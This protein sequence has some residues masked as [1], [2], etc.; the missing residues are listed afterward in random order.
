MDVDAV[1]PQEDAVPQSAPLSEAQVLN[2]A[3][4]FVYKIDDFARLRRFTILGSEANNYYV[5]RDELELQNA[6]CVL[7]LLAEGQGDR[8]VAEVKAISLEG[9]A[10]RQTSGI[11]VLAMCAR[12]GDTATRRAALAALPA[13]CRT[14]STLFEF[15]QRCKELGAAARHARQDVAAAADPAAILSWVAQAAKDTTAAADDSGASGGSGSGGKL[16]GKRGSGTR[17]AV[18][19]G[20]GKAS[21][22]RAMRRAVSNWYLGRTPAAVAYQA[23][24]YSQRNGWSHADVLRLAHPDP[25]AHAAK[26]RK[27]QQ[28]GRQEQRQQ[29]APAVGEGAADSDGSDSDTEWV[30]LPPAG[31]AADG[32][33]GDDGGAASEQVALAAAVAAAAAA[34]AATHVSEGV[35]PAE[36]AAAAKEALCTADMKAVFAFLTHGTLPGR[37]PRARGRKAAPAAAEAAPAAAEAAAAVEGCEDPAS[38]AFTTATASTTD[39]DAAATDAPATAADHP[40]HYQKCDV[41]AFKDVVRASTGGTLV[42]MDMRSCNPAT[43]AW[44]V[45]EW[46]ATLGAHGPDGLH[47]QV[48]AADRAALV[49]SLDVELAECYSPDDKIAILRDVVEQHGSTSEFNDKLKLQLMLQPLSYRVDLRRLTE[50]ARGTA[51]RFGPVHDW[52]DAGEGGAR[53]LCVLAGAGE[54]KSTISAALCDSAAAGQ[55]VTA[56]HFV[57]YSD[58]RRLDPLRAISSLAFQLADRLPAIRPH[59]FKVD[60]SKLATTTDPGELFE[61]LL[62]APLQEALQPPAAATVAA[63]A[64]GEEAPQEQHAAGAG[65]AASSQQVVLLIDALDEADP[66]VASSLPDPGGASGDG[67]GGSGHGAAASEPGAP[68]VEVCG[69]KIFQLLTRQLKSLPRCVRFILTARPDAVSGDLRALLDRSFSGGGGVAYLT[70]RQLRGEPDG[71]DDGGG[72]G[73][74]GGGGGAAAAAADGSNAGGSGVLVYHTLVNECTAKVPDAADALQS[75]AAA[76]APAGPPALRDLHVAYGCI[77]TARMRRL[78][79]AEGRAVHELLAVLLAAQEPLPHSLLHALGLGG[80]LALLPGYPVTFFLDEHHVYTL[81]KSL[82][83]W[84]AEPA[85]SGMHAADAAAGH[86]RLAERL[87]S[88]VRGTAG[89]GGG[90]SL[91]EYAL[92]YLV[93]HLVACGDLS[94]LEA[95]LRDYGF[96]AAVFAQGHGHGVIR[97][98]LRAAQPTPGVADARRWLL[99]RQHELVGVRAAEDVLKDALD[100]PVGTL[101]YLAAQEHVLAGAAAAG[102][103]RWR[104]Q[105]TLGARTTWP[106]LRISMRG[107][108]GWISSVAWSPDGRTVASGM[109]G[110]RVALWNAAS[111]ECIVV[112]DGHTDVVSSVCWQP[113][114]RALASGSH[115]GTVRLWDAAS[116]ECMGTL[117]GC[118]DG[119]SSVAWSPDGR[120]L[121]GGSGNSIHCWDAAS[122]EATTVLQGHSAPVRGVAWRPDSGA[123]ASASNDQMLRL[124]DPKS[125]ACTAVLKGH[126]GNALTVAWSPDGG[127]LASGG[128][129]EMLVRLWDAGPAVTAGGGGAGTSSVALSQ[130][131]PQQEQVHAE[132]IASVSWSPDG[133]AIASASMDKTLR[134]WDAASGEC[135]ATL[136]GHI[137][138]VFSVA[139][140]PSGRALA[141][142]SLDRTV[143]LWDAAS[144]ECTATLEG[145]GDQ[146]YSVSWSPDGG[147]VA[148]G[149]WDASVRVWDAS[150]GACTSTLQNSSG[151]V[152]GVAWSPGG[153]QLA[154]AL[155]KAVL[156]YDMPSGSTAAT[157][158]GHTAQVVCVAWSPDGRCLLSGGWD[159]CARVWDVA[160]GQCTATLQG[161]TMWIWSVAWSPDGGSLATF[162]NDASLRVWDAASGECSATVQVRTL[163]FSAVAW[164]PDS[165]EL[166]CSVMDKAGAGWAVRVYAREG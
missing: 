28:G 66:S 92:K 5:K 42:V 87:L 106:V 10:P 134:V 115:D 105:R 56:H 36:A 122:G 2:N 77:F 86:A 144:G 142:G 15:V 98:L 110:K 9:R 154:C 73:S 67:G 13:V 39:A 7:R 129:N 135:R 100:C 33:G 111:G 53:V 125:G 159:M 141:S 89:G 65:E 131:L 6:E 145:H 31:A 166:A 76:A 163:W 94:S 14:A 152:S 30:V 99:A 90:G 107:S 59:L 74:A 17:P 41:A 150:T 113:N 96:L 153:Q 35:D 63:A 130:A 102:K 25:E 49:G 50:R 162:G 157:L 46:A 108:S 38:A 78:K 61:R 101:S 4:G 164:S 126:A 133:A 62:R 29:A 109:G 128:D 123:V 21:W 127:T 58:Q 60:V 23:T 93:R 45:Y 71:A 81:H 55:G 139:W 32:E 155:D 37:E 83:D 138:K 91:S 161:H 137:G 79:R 85:A 64:E 117:E 147:A 34:L 24:K 20:G 124:W 19:G 3:G 1:A 72:A 43:R 27:L 12:F 140:S 40:T 103:A 18:C 26:R 54:G 112:L 149:S 51:W 165:S 47:M 158:E 44:C 120:T 132:T 68:R 116:G 95:L 151:R 82:A 11:F 8:V 57:K 97:D 119:V 88:A 114:G 70:P 16:G 104:L 146:V 75:R 118:P 136:L 52:L 160:S 84:L 121:A 48:D 156:L 80:A 22:G 69:N 143:R 148:S